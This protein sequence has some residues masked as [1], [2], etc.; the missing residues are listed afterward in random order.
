MRDVNQMS[1]VNRALMSSQVSYSP[2]IAVDDM[3]RIQGIMPGSTVVHNPIVTHQPISI[4]RGQAPV[5][6]VSVTLGGPRS[7]ARVY[8]PESSRLLE[9]QQR[10]NYGINLPVYKAVNHFPG[11]DDNTARA[12]YNQNAMQLQGYCNPFGV[13]NPFMLPQQGMFSFPTGYSSQSIIDREHSDT[14]VTSVPVTSQPTSIVSSGSRPTARPTQSNRAVQSGRRTPA[15][16]VSDQHTL[17]SR[18]DSDSDQEDSSAE[19]FSVTSDRAYEQDQYGVH[20]DESAHADMAE[21][22]QKLSLLFSAARIDP[23]LHAA[24]EEFGLQIGDQEEEEEHQGCSLRFGGV[25]MDR[26]LH[27]PILSMQYDIFRERDRL[28]KLKWSIIP[29]VFC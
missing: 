25:G 9:Q 19:D 15:A 17:C 6:S 24:S 26:D 14:I 4:N 7:S 20:D 23:I 13:F 5:K 22:V 21:A 27:D 16:P 11:M 8:N 3:T 18:S 10:P 12:L 28:A 29:V 2:I 1:D